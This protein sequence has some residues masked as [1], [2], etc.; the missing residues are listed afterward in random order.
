MAVIELDSALKK[1]ENH[2]PEVFLKECKYIEKRVVRHIQQNLSD[3]SYSSSDD[4]DE[5]FLWY[6]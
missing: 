4:D 3:F 6:G 2:Y 1:D 5:L